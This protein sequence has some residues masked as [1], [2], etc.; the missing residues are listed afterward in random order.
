MLKDPALTK[1]LQLCTE[2]P[3]P[4][5]IAIRIIELCQDPDTSLGEVASVIGHDPAISAKLMRMANSPLY[6]RQRK[7]ENIRQAISL[8]GLNGTLTLALGFSVVDSS[9]QQGGCLDHNHFWRR[10]LACA[11]SSQ[12]LGAR[13]EP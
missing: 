9:R 5:G 11:I 3:S 1:K 12:L 7:I 8:F 10:S 2:L 4:A 6:A 13:L